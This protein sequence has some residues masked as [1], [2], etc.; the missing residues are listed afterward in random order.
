MVHLN[1]AIAAAMVHGP[2]RGLA[3]LEP[4]ADKL[5]GHHRLHSVRA[6]LLEMAGDEDAA[7]EEYRVAANKTTSVPERLYLMQRA[8]ALRQ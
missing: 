8:A 2:A 6:H 1:H 3:L 4:L 5:S 7:F